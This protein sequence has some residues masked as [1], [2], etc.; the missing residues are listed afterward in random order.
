MSSLHDDKTP[1]V[2]TA[3]LCKHNHNHV[4]QNENILF[5][6]VGPTLEML[7][8]NMKSDTTAVGPF[9]TLI[10]LIHTFLHFGIKIRSGVEECIVLD[11]D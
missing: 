4:G 5:P 11:A 2:N 1:Q 8:T 9:S 3:Q 7:H 10:H 6:V